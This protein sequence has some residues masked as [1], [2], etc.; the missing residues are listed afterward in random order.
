MHEPMLKNCL[1]HMVY[2]CNEGVEESSRDPNSSIITIGLLFVKLYA[3][4]FICFVFS[5]L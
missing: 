1:V 5:E 4:G 2:E 3:F